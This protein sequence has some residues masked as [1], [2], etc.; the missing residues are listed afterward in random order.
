MA[1]RVHGSKGLV[2]FTS[3]STNLPI[4]GWEGT[5]SVGVADAGVNDGYTNAVGGNKSFRG[6]VNCMWD[7]LL[8]DEVVPTPFEEGDSVELHLHP[9]D[10]GGYWL[11]QALITEMPIRVQGN[12]AVTWSFS[13]QN[14]GEYSW[15]PVV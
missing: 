9:S 6:T 2:K 4:T 7:K 8:E 3:G 13:F 15:V 11:V 1:T 12:A 14:Q 5:K 10:G